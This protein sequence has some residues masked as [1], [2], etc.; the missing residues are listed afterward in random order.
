M[1]N[2]LNKT[3][4]FSEN[5]KNDQSQVFA[6]IIKSIQIPDSLKRKY[7]LNDIGSLGATL[8]IAN[9]ASDSFKSSSV[10]EFCLT[11]SIFVR[12]DRAGLETSITAFEGEASDQDK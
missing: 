3:A 12:L 7:V 2:E 6:S 8:A 9:S 5:Q 11:K 10:S 1:Q 4:L